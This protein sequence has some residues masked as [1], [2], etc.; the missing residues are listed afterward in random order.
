MSLALHYNLKH[1][2]A[3]KTSSILTLGGIALVV[4]VAA[5]TLML[6]A[7]LRKTLSQT[8]SPHRVIV[9]R[10]GS[11]NEMQSSVARQNAAIILSDPAVA[12]LPDGSPSGTADLLV[13]VTLP[14]KPD[15]NKV[16]VNFRGVSPGAYS[17]RAMIKLVEG[18]L[19]Q[20]GTNEVIVG[21]NVSSRFF[22][23]G[24][25]STLKMLGTQW[26]IVGIFDGGN[27]AFST[28][29]WTDVDILMPAAKRSAFSSV[30]FDLQP[31]TDFA[32]LESRLENDPR[33]GVD[34]RREDE[35]Y[36]AQSKQ[37]SSFISFVGIVVSIVF[38]LGAI[39]GAMITMYS[40]VA[41]R[42]REIGV[43]RALGFSAATVF[44]A[45]LKECLLIS[46]SGGLV[47]LLIAF[48]L[49]F[50]AISTTNFD[51]FAEV[52][53]NFALTPQIAAGVLL[54][55][56]VMGVLGGA[57]PALHAARLR[58]TDILRSE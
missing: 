30:V 38:S 31:G 11:Q 40:A 36:A 5:S 12:R 25:G 39:V 42:T 47:G 56:A 29:L 28:E 33:L 14:K 41:H 26:P 1:L 57:L 32:E 20:R 54:F 15:G 19:P 17:V 43:L 4:F 53:F 23:A 37:L 51:S 16:N 7:G 49:T 46:L 6:S 18:R 55:A 9:V 44:M 3:R 50:V 27:T 2:L 52:T 13:V 8:G 10:D 22:D 21:R 24:P 48:M 34:I 58:I 35:F 45:F